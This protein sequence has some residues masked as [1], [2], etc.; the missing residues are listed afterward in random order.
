M[1]PNFA[2]LSGKWRDKREI[3]HGRMVAGDSG[4]FSRPTRAREN[5]ILSLHTTAVGFTL[6][7]AG[8]PTSKGTQ[9][10][11]G[12]DS[13]QEEGATTSYLTGWRGDPS[14]CVHSAKI[15]ELRANASSIDVRPKTGPTH[16]IAAEPGYRT[17]GDGCPLTPGLRVGG[18]LSPVLAALMAGEGCAAPL[19]IR[20][21]QKHGKEGDTERYSRGGERAAR[22]FG[23]CIASDS[24]ATSEYP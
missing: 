16:A 3:A 5:T 15:A 22:G 8:A 7:M 20:K 6:D 1:Y 11:L 10:P 24:G 23:Y 4:R 17:L 13:S 12:L 21:L 2:E 18:A 9:M 19:P 14:S